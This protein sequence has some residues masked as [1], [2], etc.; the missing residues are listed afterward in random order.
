VSA[1]GRAIDGSDVD[2]FSVLIAY[3]RA[4]DSLDGQLDEL[5]CPFLAIVATSGLE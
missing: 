5:L 4:G 1:V 2:R 3:T